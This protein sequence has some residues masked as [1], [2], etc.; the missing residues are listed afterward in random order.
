MSYVQGL[1]QRGQPATAIKGVIKAEQV[2][3]APVRNQGRDFGHY[4]KY[5]AR[6]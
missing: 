2:I 4:Q 1:S 6:S 5:S 3:D